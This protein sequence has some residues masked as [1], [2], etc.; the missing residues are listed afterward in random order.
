MALRAYM[1]A[2][3][4]GSTR[5]HEGEE[6][7]PRVGNF[8]NELV[9]R[10]RM[11]AQIYV[12]VESSAKWD[13]KSPLAWKSRRGANKGAKTGEQTRRGQ[14]CE[15]LVELPEAIGK[16]I[17]LRHLHAADCIQLQCL[18][19]GIDRELIKDEQHEIEEIEFLQEAIG[20][21]RRTLTP[22][23]CNVSS[24]DENDALSI[25]SL[26]NVKDVYEAG[27]AELKNVVLLSLE[28]DFDN[29]EDERIKG[30][31]ELLDVLRPDQVET[32]RVAEYHGLTVPPNWTM[33]LQT[34]RHLILE[35]WT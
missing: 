20:R 6:R 30:D 27:K 15:G 28:L 1:K 2:R 34:L 32:L 24:G 25:K 35:E 13:Q 33:P 10:V 22:L 23:G 19:E 12:Q 18:P 14:R 5:V 16:L 11:H 7:W 8:A 29:E 4:D 3:R 21:L 17:G 9:S 31:A 26:G